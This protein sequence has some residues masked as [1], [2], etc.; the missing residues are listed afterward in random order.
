MLA[1][2]TAGLNFK[3]S[4]M[5]NGYIELWWK[6]FEKQRSRWRWCG[7]WTRENREKWENILRFTKFIH[8]TLMSVVPSTS[9]L[10]Y[11]EADCSSR[12][13]TK[14]GNISSNERIINFP[15]QSSRDLFI[16]HQ[17]I[18][19]HILKTKSG[20]SRQQI[21]NFPTICRSLS[22]LPAL[23]SLFA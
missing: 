18:P 1:F 9:T 3:P 6:K 20:N 11:A 21:L 5:K 23:I 4:I 17:K 10:I 19:S 12:M 22:A 16:K 2:D 8:L 13:R 7:G 15:H 14:K